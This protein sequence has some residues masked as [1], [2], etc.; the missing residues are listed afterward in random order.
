MNHTKQE[1]YTSFTSACL[2]L[3]KAIKSGWNISEKNPPSMLGFNF[4][5][6]YERED[7]PPLD[8]AEVLMKARAAKA[9]KRQ[10]GGSE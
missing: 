6:T 8:R 3:E 5:I 9:A 1:L 2:A 7:A 10:Q 4:E